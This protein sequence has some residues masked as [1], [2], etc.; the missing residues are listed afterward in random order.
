MPDTRIV[1]LHS[2]LWC[3][4][5]NE[6]IIRQQEFWRVT[7]PDRFV[8]NFYQEADAIAYA[9]LETRYEKA[10]TALRELGELGKLAREIE[11]DWEHTDDCQVHDYL[12]AVIAAADALPKAAEG[13]K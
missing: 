2:T 10:E 5:K 12:Q 7:T 8:A 9:A 1:I 3:G 6:N 13:V 4:D 11:R